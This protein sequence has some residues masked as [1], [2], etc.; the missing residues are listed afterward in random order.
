MVAGLRRYQNVWEMFLKPLKALSCGIGGDRI[1]LV[2]W[3]ALN[4]PFFKNLG[5]VV[6]LCGTNNVQQDSSE[7]ILDGN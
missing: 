4:L 1:E 3:R 6:V 5:N 7:D 2:L